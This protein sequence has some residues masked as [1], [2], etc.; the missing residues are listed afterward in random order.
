MRGDL[1]IIFP[2]L[3][4]SG[5]SHSHS[6]PVRFPPLGP[7]FSL[8]TCER[9]FLLILSRD[10]SLSLPLG[11]SNR[12]T[13]ANRHCPLHPD[14]GVK[15]DRSLSSSK[16]FENRSVSRS[17]NENTSDVMNQPSSSTGTSGK[18]QK[19]NRS[20]RKSA[21]SI[22]LRNRKLLQELDAAD[23]SLQK[24]NQGQS[25]AQHHA[26]HESTPVLLESSRVANNITNTFSGTPSQSSQREAD[27][28]VWKKK[29]AALELQKKQQQ[30][31]LPGEGI[32][33]QELVVAASTQCD[34][35]SSLPR[36]K[37]LGVLALMELSGAD[38]SNETRQLLS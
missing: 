5:P 38:V 33:I 31:D 10:S 4:A 14:V 24:E 37:L 8:Q 9:M 26:I 1:C 11:C 25:V 29:R 21:G 7:S 3:T 34:N 23:D 13:H 20:G 22:K 15:R 36:D 12:F 16:S 28:I 17:N 35:N 27:D 2:P 6:T 18:K 32:E 30:Q 19:Q